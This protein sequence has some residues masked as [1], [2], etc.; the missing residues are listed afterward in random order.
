MC[1]KSAN[2][3]R[4]F[5]KLSASECWIVEKLHQSVALITFRGIDAVVSEGRGAPPVHGGEP[6]RDHATHG[7]RH[8]A[9]DPRGGSAVVA[10]RG[11]LPGVRPQLRGLGRRR[12]G[13]PARRAQPPRLPQGARRRRALVQPLVPLAARRRRLR[14]LG[15]PRHPPHL[16]HPR[17]RRAAHQ[18]GPRARHPD[19]HRH[20]PEPRLERAPLVPAGP[21]GSAGQLRAGA[22]LVPPGQGPERRR[23]A[24]AP[25]SRTSRATRG[26]AP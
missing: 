18:R 21:R 16:R 10:Q 26:R 12:H 25:G 5:T 24:H 15:L 3:S 11:D 22:L 4:K 19:D 6:Q 20:R 1:R 7:T 9:P 17:G 2:R 8:G 14:R 13:R 23:D